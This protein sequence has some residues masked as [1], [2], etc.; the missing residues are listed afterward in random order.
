MKALQSYQSQFEERMLILSLFIVIS[1]AFCIAFL[2]IYVGYSE[3]A[4][5][6]LCVLLLGF[7]IYLLSK[8]FAI[9]VSL[10]LFLLVSAVFSNF[11]E[12]LYGQIVKEG[13]L[14]LI[15]L[16]WLLSS[17]AS[18]RLV[19]RN[20]KTGIPEFVAVI[21]ILFLLVELFR[22]HPVVGFFGFRS[23]ALFLPLFLFVPGLID[24]KHELIRLFK[25]LFIGLVAVAI[26]AIAQHFFTEM[27]MSSLGFSYGD[28]GYRSTLGY[29]KASS[30]L[31]DPAASG[32]LISIAL[33]L[34]FT[35]W[36][37]GRQMVLSKSKIINL[38]LVT[39][40]GS[41]LIFTFSRISWIATIFG[42]FLIVT[43]L[44]LK[45]IRIFGI[46]FLILVVANF[47]LDNFIFNHFISSFGLGSN[48]RG[49][50]STLSRIQILD[51][52]L[53]KYVADN[54]LFGHGL[55]IT[56]APSMRNASLLHGGYQVMD[57]Y[58]L[59]LLVETGLVGAILFLLFIGLS[60]WVGIRQFQLLKNREL[61]TL[62]LGIAVTIFVIAFVS[63]ATAVL[64]SPV[65]NIYLWIFIGLLHSCR[66][67]DRL[68]PHDQPS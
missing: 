39:I 27:I 2:C 9:L 68:D 7:L 6:I 61:A 45:L 10:M 51:T 44:R 56:G 19:L 66:A 46:G 5:L 64:E 15:V 20:L 52:V 54:P 50:E 16:S 47:L 49:I 34:Y 58:Y 57:N 28:L 21:W 25:I 11:V 59:K 41:G 8:P 67:L 40:L 30:T 53:N 29:L 38:A 63:T 22:Q 32:V 13:L 23:V 65:I 31:G 17:L 1:L 12:G 3:I 48:I 18:G 33:L 62:S 36:F 35:F 37:S 60:I 55:G 24:N 43:F 42:L 14:L 4:I 26:V